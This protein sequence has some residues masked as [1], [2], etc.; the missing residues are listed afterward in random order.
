MK[1]DLEVLVIEAKRHR[2]G[3]KRVRYPVEFRKSAVAA[4]RYHG[5]EDLVKELGVGLSTLQKWKKSYG[6]RGKEGTAKLPVA[7]SFTFAPILS[8]QE[9][10]SADNKLGGDSD[11]LLEFTDHH[12]RSFKISMPC[13]ELTA[14]KVIKLCEQAFAIGG[15]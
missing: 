14:D 5:Y 1:M 7:D 12:S 2:V 9:K 11:I 13:N 15:Q 3:K 6:T 8:R 4:L 10:L